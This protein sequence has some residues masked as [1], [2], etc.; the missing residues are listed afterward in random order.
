MGNPISKPSATIRAALV[1]L[2]A[3]ASPYVDAQAPGEIAPPVVKEGATVKISDHVY[4]IPDG[5][6]AMVPNVGIIV[7]TRAT[8]VVDPGMGV[9]SGQVVLR[10]VAR[11]SRNT[12]LYIVNTHFH[13]EH[14]TGE[15]AFPADTRIV[16]AKVQQQE[17]EELGLKHVST[18]ASRS[19]VIAGVLKIGRAHV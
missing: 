10:E 16:R 8:L 1:A 14:T 9:A 11:V 15:A 17:L 18:F 6:A 2:C 4:V 12:E 3:A 13:S 5:K 19:P 7:G